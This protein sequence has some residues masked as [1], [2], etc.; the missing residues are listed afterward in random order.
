MGLTKETE[1]ATTKRN[2][3]QHQQS[4]VSQRAALR[5]KRNNLSSPQQDFLDSQKSF[6]IRAHTR[7][8]MPKM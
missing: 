6:Q 7:S 4:P 2:F 8:H 3:P 1:F 5:N